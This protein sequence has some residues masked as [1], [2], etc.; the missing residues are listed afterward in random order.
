[1]SSIDS[2]K[3][4]LFTIP[5]AD[6]LSWYGKRVDHRG[7][8]YFSPF[9]DEDTPSMRVTVNPSDGTWIWADFGGSPAAGKKADG[10][11]CLEMVRRLGGFSSDKSAF[12][13]LQRIAD[14][15]GIILA[16]QGTYSPRCREEVKPSGIV[17]DDVEMK[18]T[19]KSLRDY[20]V[21]VR[22]IPEALLEKYCRQVIYHARSNANRHYYAIGFPNNSAG[23]VLRGS[24]APAKSKRNYLSGITTVSAVGGFSPEGGVSHSKCALFEGFMDF[25]SYL[26]WRGVSEPGIDVCVLNSTSMLSQAKDWI[27]SH[28]A[29][30]TFFDND[31]TGD[32]ATECV[33]E[34]SREAGKDFRDGREAYI[35]FDDINECWVAE[36]SRRKGVSR[37]GPDAEKSVSMKIK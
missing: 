31:P 9:R 10:G 13:E 4:L 33:K 3:Q 29:V 25:L 18:F 1:M 12:E 34:W 21:G 30:R 23:F 26:A 36:L 17:I 8:M 7:Y 11:G 2:N 5:V 32:K 19:R 6:V 37:K 15:K 35:G 28:E 24:G 27:M 14:S 16:E 22:G 20:A